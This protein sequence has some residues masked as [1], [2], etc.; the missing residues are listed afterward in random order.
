MRAD[1][2]ISIMLLLSGRGKLTTRV[3][4]QT[5][6]VSRRTILRDVDALSTAGI[7]IYSEGGRGGGI[8]LDEQYRISLTGL[9]KDEL[10]A[11][12][13]A[14]GDGPL[15]DLGLNSASEST[16]LKL[17]AGLPSLQRD[18]VA[19]FRQRIYIDPQW[20]WHD[21]M[22]DEPFLPQLQQAVYEDR[23]IRAVYATRDGTT[24][25]RMLEPF[26]LVAKAG[27]WY[28]VARRD[29]ELR[30]YRVSRLHDVT[31]LDTHF[32]RPNDYDLSAYWQAH[33][34][35][36]SAQLTPYTFTV[37]IRDD[38]RQFAE[39]YGSARRQVLAREPGWTTVRYAV[40]SAEVAEMFVFGLG[41]NAVILEPPE[42]HEAVRAKASAVLA[43]LK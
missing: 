30:T 31:L 28:L 35:T 37:R 32:Q 8:W 18:T 27:I 23:C 6:E 9:N 19:D 22:P 17:F 7:P 21:Q 26:S 16:L 12:F 15:R 41:G 20:W 14:T 11:T 40:E 13:I 42:L 5:L 36:F 2:L 34:G 4:A 3:L 39:W 29:G 38:I 33:A 24:T 25:A 10:Y 1:R 43:A